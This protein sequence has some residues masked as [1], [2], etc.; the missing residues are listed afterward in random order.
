MT[1]VRNMR[2]FTSSTQ[3]QGFKDLVLYYFFFECFQVPHTYDHCV[4]LAL[5]LDEPISFCHLSDE[6]NH[7]S[8]SWFCLSSFVIFLT[9]FLQGF[10]MASFTF[11]VLFPVSSPTGP[12][13]STLRVPSL[14]QFS[15]CGYFFY[16]IYLEL[17]F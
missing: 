11:L 6:K 8:V 12:S 7:T 1:L 2:C 15:Y 16:S 5:K 14:N 10:Q 9:N 17:S 3:E 13:S 4:S